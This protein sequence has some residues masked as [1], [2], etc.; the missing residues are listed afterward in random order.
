MWRALHVLQQENNSM[1]Q[2]F[3][4]L[5]IGVPPAPQNPGGAINQ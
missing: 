2:A 4:R 3:E 5:Q 1:R